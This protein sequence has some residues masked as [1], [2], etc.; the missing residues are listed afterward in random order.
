LIDLCQE[1]YE[2]KSVS[3]IFIQKEYSLLE[4]LKAEEAYFYGFSRDIQQFFGHSISREEN[5]I[6]GHYNEHE[7]YLWAKLPI[8]IL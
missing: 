5:I 4:L 6:L 1:I 2:K 8:S 3:R 7:T